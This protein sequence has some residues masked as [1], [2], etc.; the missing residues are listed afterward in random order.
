MSDFRTKLLVLAAM[1]M[2]TAGASFGQDQIY[3]AVAATPT[4]N[5]AAASGIVT[6][7]RSEGQTELVQDI[8]AAPAGVAGNITTTAGGCL[9]AN[10]GVPTATTGTFYVTVNAQ[11]TSRANG[12]AT[13]ATL[14]IYNTTAAPPVGGYTP[15]TYAGS[16]V[17]NTVVFANVAYPA[18]FNFQVA[19]IRINASTATTPNITEAVNL[20]YV[21]VGLGGAN[22]TS[23]NLISGNIPVGYVQ[24]SLS[25][26]L[27]VLAGLPAGTTFNNYLTCAGN[28]VTL[29]GQTTLI[30]NSVTP[31]NT[32]NT[33]FQINLTEIWPGAF[34]IQSAPIGTGQSGEQ[35]SS[36]FAAAPAVLEA[37]NSA[38]QIQITMA[39]VPAS[40]TVYV[41]VTLTQGAVLTPTT[42]ALAGITPLT[43][44]Q[45]TPVPGNIYGFTPT[46]GVVT[47]TYTV[48]TAFPTTSLTFPIPVEM[49]FAANSA[50]AQGAVT[51]A[52]NYAPTAATLTGA[53]AVVPTFVPPS[54]P[55]NVGII[56]TCQTTLLFPYVTNANGF[57]T[58]IAIANTT[59][60]N[61]GATSTAAPNGTSIGA[62]IPGTCTV[63]FYG[64][65]A[66]PTAATF[67]PTG[68]V[69]A[70]TTASGSPSPIYADTLSHSSGTTG[71]TGYA[72]ANC[73]YPGAHGFAYI[74]DGFGTS[75]GTAQGYLG[76][77]ITGRSDIG[78]NF[79]N[80]N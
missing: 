70:W 64:N 43:G 58:G 78:N 51:L 27:A 57:E 72:I 61:L 26:K 15:T 48:A 32:T 55:S 19:N 59:T 79:G 25:W 22:T 50:A 44:K 46:N 66:Q 42:I 5:I 67:P 47:I 12:G 36:T 75:A 29:P 16:I 37:A 68:T 76:I 31:Y 39:N 74:V 80:A 69:G 60:D 77:V 11:V 14:L 71:F 13:D 8:I 49:T 40:A 62:P 73:N 24:Q 23:A 41:P 2:A 38:T 21:S 45:F 9:S 56:A 7:L 28:P 20:E 34:K 10:G 33:S 17:G 65:Q 52:V 4:S 18:S 1:G 3:C 6:T 63:N 30:V 35:G 53:S 54:T